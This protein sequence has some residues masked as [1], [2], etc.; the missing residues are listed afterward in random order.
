MPNLTSSIFNEFFV[1]E[2]NNTWRHWHACYFV[3]FWGNPPKPDL[4]SEIISLWQWFSHETKLYAF[5]KRIIPNV[6]GLLTLSGWPLVGLLWPYRQAPSTV[7]LAFQH[8]VEQLQFNTQFC[9]SF[10]VQII[11]Q[12]GRTIWIHL[13]T[14]VLCC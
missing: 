13:K 11:W 7:V 5:Y 9:S 10:K 3:I 4:T 8:A 12:K 2:K 1:M 6:V 14:T